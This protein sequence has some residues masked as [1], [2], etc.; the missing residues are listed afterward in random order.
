MNVDR[1]WWATSVVRGRVLAAGLVLLG[2]GC[3][4][5]GL[6]SRSLYSVAN[7]G[8]VHGFGVPLAIAPTPAAMPG[9]AETRATEARARSLFAG[10]PLIFEP[11]QGQADLDPA[12]S[13]ARF[14]TRGSGYS[15]FLGSQ[16]AILSMVSH[17]S[18]KQN[19]KKRK[20]G[21]ATRVD[22]L[23]MKLAGAN[24][25]AA[26]SGTE[27][28]PGKSNYFMGN[29]PAKWRAGVPQFA[30]VRYD[31]IYPGI[32]LVFYGNQGQLEYDFQ[33]APGADPSQAELEFHGA[34]Q[35]ELSQGALVITQ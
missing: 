31:N 12:D 30:R 21:S 6:G 23:E 22:S 7:A 18:A 17:D 19:S 10:L 9:L 24:P 26:V 20:A 34:K 33:V 16:G 29:D 25:N 35:M 4:I 3:A 1:R 27:L 32:N 5:L 8:T 14:V 15:L 13:R 28:L 11:N 2:T